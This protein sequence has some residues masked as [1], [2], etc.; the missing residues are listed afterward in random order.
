MIWPW[1]PLATLLASRVAGGLAQ[2][3]VSRCLEYLQHYGYLSAGVSDP[4]FVGEAVRRFRQRFGLHEGDSLDG[5]VERAMSWPRCGV[6]D[7]LA[8]NAEEARWRKTKL[9]YFVQSYVSGL[10]KAD[11][12][13]LLRLA[14]QDWMAVA[15]ITITPTTSVSTA[16][17]VISTGRGRGSNFDGPSGT[18]AWAYLPNG[19][20]QQLL[21]RFDLDETWVRDS[22]QRGILFKA[23]A[24]HEFGHL[25]GLDHSRQQSALMAPY[26]APGVT[27]PQAVDDVTRIQSLYGPPV[28]T[29][30]NPTPARPEI[31]IRFD[32]KIPTFTVT[33]RGG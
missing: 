18:L 19:Q 8:L 6:S 16:D 1:N 26:Y 27:S 33:K 31:I 7:H 13:D 3:S 17:I 21:M 2:Q 32:D 22:S 9:T 23:V 10:S 30:D 14:W 29:P 24:C 5:Q 20:D 25:L 28:T 12:D 4:V 11:Q 15:G